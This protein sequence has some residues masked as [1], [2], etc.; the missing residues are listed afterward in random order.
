MNIIGN[1]WDYLEHCVWSRDPLP[2]SED[3]LW[4]ALKEEWYKIPLS[5]IMKL[6]ESCPQHIADLY[7]AGGNATRYSGLQNCS[8]VLHFHKVFLIEN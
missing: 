4:E 5:Y 7:C 6:Y 1:L 3:T 2:T 8:N